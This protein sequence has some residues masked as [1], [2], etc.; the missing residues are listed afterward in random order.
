MYFVYLIKSLFSDRKCLGCTSDLA[1]RL[2]EHN[3]GLVKSTKQFKP[4]K[5]IYYEA[6]LNKYDAFNREKELKT[7]YTKKKYL[8]GRLKNSLK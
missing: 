4:W 7:T 2:R 1:R 5:L 8:L 3:N 6:F